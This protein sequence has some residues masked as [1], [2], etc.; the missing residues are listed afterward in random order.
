MEHLQFGVDI[1]TSLAIIGAFFSWSIDNHRQRRLAR[2]IGINDQARAIAA[3]KVQDTTW[4]L[5]KRFIALVE[6]AQKIERRIDHPYADD[7]IDGIARRIE[8]DDAYLQDISFH[9]HA[10]REELS[11]FYEACHT[12][13]YVLFPVLKTLPEGDGLVSSVSKDFTDI[14]NCHNEL[15]S[16]Y[17]ALLREIEQ[18]GQLAREI[19]RES[20]EDEQQREEVRY[21]M[22]QAVQSIVF[23]EDYSE[24]VGYLI[25]Q[26]REED[27]HREYRSKEVQDAELC[28][29]VIENLYQMLQEDL[30]KLQGVCLL[31]VSQSVMNARKECKE[32]LCSL[33][34]VASV[35][36]TK[37]ENTSLAAEIAVF[38]SEDYYGLKGQIR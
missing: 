6:H 37:Q 36:L 24:F 31:L 19:A 11:L 20:V 28:A 38:K 3:N 12:H 13:K 8:K 7:G 4:D 23:D 2:E 30:P 33:S 29:L 5:S 27:F 25:P 26:G 10:L 14:G 21:K 16:G 22:R 1:A 15:S 18:A 9:L 34:A 35:L 32:V 17:S